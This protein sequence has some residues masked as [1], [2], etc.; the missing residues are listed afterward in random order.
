MSESERISTKK[1][2]WRP[3]TRV[4]NRVMQVAM[5]AVIG[6]WSFYGIFRCPFIVPYINCQNCPV[7]T[8][9]GRILSLFWGFWIGWG[10][11]AAFFGRAFCGWLCPGGLANRL[12][13]SFSRLRLKRKSLAQ[14]LLPWGK[15]L[16]LALAL[17]VI[18]QMN[19]PRVNV[20]IRVG[21]FFPAI[22]QTWNFAQPI[23]IVR[24]LF[25]LALLALGIL[26]PAAWCRFA[27]P[28]GG[29]LELAKRFSLFRIFK[30]EACNGCDLCKKACYMDTRPEEGNCTNCGDCIQS[31]PQKCI[32][33]GRKR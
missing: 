28:T 9:H 32:G 31:C 16:G 17:W 21:E 5:L 10:A 15:Y 33:L 18:L 24:T 3:K 7:I 8:C 13:G 6:Q 22:A 19:Q 4:F 29:A 26:L 12:L 2:L 11:L 27:C 30:T 14:K 23:W 20:P 1:A 25:V